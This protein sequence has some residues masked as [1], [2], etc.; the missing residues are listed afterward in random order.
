MSV[1]RELIAEIKQLEQRLGMYMDDDVVPGNGGVA[2]PMTDDAL[3]T[4]ASIKDPSGIEEQITQDK[5]TE[6][7]GETHGEEL[8]TFPSTEEAGRKSPGLTVKSSDYTSR[9]K[10]ASDR[11]DRVADYLEKHGR[12]EMAH[13]IDK[14]ADALDARIKGGK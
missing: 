4:C 10:S 14:I 6:V 3:A 7:E 8:A 9:L 5:F 12:R 2:E 1:R 13:R 11:L